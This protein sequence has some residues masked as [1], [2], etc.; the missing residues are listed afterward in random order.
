MKGA[1]RRLFLLPRGSVLCCFDDEGWRSR[2]L[3]GARAHAKM[4]D[5]L[6]NECSLMQATVFRYLSYLGLALG[7]V[8]SFWVLR[9]GALC[10]LF[11]IACAHLYGV[12]RAE[13]HA[14]NTNESLFVVLDVLSQVIKRV[15]EI[16]T[17]APPQAGSLPDGRSSTEPPESQS[18]R[19]VGQR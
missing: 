5:A 8:L 6:P 14:H 3:R 15:D 1:A 10:F 18:Q 17:G 7:I 11:S 16:R 2:Q 13:A 12:A 4:E 9:W 19:S